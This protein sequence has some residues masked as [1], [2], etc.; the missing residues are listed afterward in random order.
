MPFGLSIAPYVQQML[1][2]GVLRFIKKYTKYTYG[3]LDD[4]II[5]HSDKRYRETFLGVL[6]AKL[7]MAGWVLNSNKSVLNPVK[8]INFLGRFR[9][10]KG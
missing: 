3:L 9:Y 8:Q 2:N 5:A 7:K 6:S 4:L 1:L 10:S